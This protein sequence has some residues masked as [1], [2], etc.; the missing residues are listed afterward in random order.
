MILVDYE[1]EDLIQEG[2]LKIEPLDEELINPASIDFRL[3]RKFGYNR[4]KPNADNDVWAL[5]C[6]NGDIGYRRKEGN[7]THLGPYIDPT[8]K[9]TIETAWFEKDGWLL[10]PHEFIL[11]C[12]AETYDF[13][14]TVATKVIG[15]SSVGRLGLENS[16]AAGFIDPGFPG[17]LV[18]EIYNYS[19]SVILLKA[20]MKIGQLVF[21]T[22]ETPDNSYK[23]T[24]RYCN[25]GG[26][27]GSKG[28]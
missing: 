4:A 14:D 16:S 5:I 23:K 1:L 8:R 25:Q 10:F 21:S 7:F 22:C 12:T 27:Q 20:G 19:D 6:K 11:A 9:E 24:G 2:K 13:P 26:D 18:L 28:V 15:K 17:V 3:G